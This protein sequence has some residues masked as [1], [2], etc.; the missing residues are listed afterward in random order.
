MKKIIAFFLIFLVFSSCKKL[1]DLNKNIKDPL[2]VSGESLFTGAQKNL[3]DQMVTPNVNLNIYRLIAQYWTETT[4]TD[5]SNYDLTTR[6]IMDGQWDA[7]Y[8]DV[9]KDF[10]EGSKI[11]TATSYPVTENVNV[12][13][14]KL[15]VTE[16]MIVF[17]FSTCVETWGN[18]PYTKALD[19]NN[20]LP[21]YDDGLT[22]YKDLIARL[23]AAIQKMKADPAAGSF[24][25]AD[26]MYHGDVGMWLKF[27]N[28]LKLHMSLLLA[29][30]DAAYAQPLAEAAATGVI[31]SNAENAK[32]VYLGSQPNN[33]PVNDNLVL[34][35]RNDFVAANTIVDMMDSLADP[36]LPFYFTKAGGVY[37]G[38]IYGASND[39]TQYS[40]VAA[41]IQEPTF[42]GTIFDYAQTEFLL[43]IGAARGWNM[44]GTAEEH[45]NK[46]IRASI[47]YWGGTTAEA[48]TYIAN[49]LVAYSATD[50]KKSIGNQM[51]LAFY[52][53]GFEAWTQWRMLDFPL[54][55][56]PVDALSDIPVRYPFP[57]E[58]QTL[59]GAN[60]T[61]ASAAIGGDDVSTKL[62]WDK[63]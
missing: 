63:H 51:W 34:S 49:P 62:F 17:T 47:E 41:K 43:A 10:T 26:N 54:L 13:Q 15:A 39:F 35:G 57:I 29:D 44:G 55:V 61:A 2:T 4:Y 7:M 25:S 14:N 23:D 42:E 56:A 16:V 3:F 24:G 52:N 12:K 28:S 1:E 50:W 48:D 19:I 60:Y 11:I 46:A 58:E 9:L 53:R 36:R 38:G 37:V 33:N 21:A 5:E 59:N 22:V 30:V 40:H 20:V 6:T 8:R 32:I 45:Y 18:V 31:A 27:A